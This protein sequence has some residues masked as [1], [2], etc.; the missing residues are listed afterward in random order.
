MFRF[1]LDTPSE[2]GILKLD[3]LLIV[4]VIYCGFLFYDQ[5]CLHLGMTLGLT[6]YEISPPELAADLSTI[7]Y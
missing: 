2:I 1:N 3:F 6:K 4:F 5:G 7:G